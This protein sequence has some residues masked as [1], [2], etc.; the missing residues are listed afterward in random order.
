MSARPWLKFYPSEWRGDPRLRM[1]SIA[2]R[3]LWMEMLCVMHEADP[4]GFLVVNGAPLNERQVANLAGVSID[5]ATGLLEE[6]EAAGVFS[7]DDNGVIYNPDMPK[8]GDG[9]YRPPIPAAVREAIK[10]RDGDTCRYCGCSDGPFEIDHVF[11]WSRGGEHT[12]ENLVIACKPC[13]RDKRDKT[14]E[15]WLH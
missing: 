1:C 5:E 14:I 11:P 12:V 3:G 10:R 13:N 2:A 15:E 4:R 7:R 8:S 9:T 6:L